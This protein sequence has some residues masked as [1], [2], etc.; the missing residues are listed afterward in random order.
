MNR[1]TLLDLSDDI[2]SI[3]MGLDS[4]DSWD[5]KKNALYDFL[6]ENLDLI[7]G[8]LV[9]SHNIGT[10][11]YFISQ[12]E[13]KSSAHFKFSIVAA[14]LNLSYNL[15]DN[16]TLFACLDAR[17][18]FLLLATNHDYFDKEL[19]GCFYSPAE[20]FQTDPDAI[21]K[22]MQ[23]YRIC[24]YFYLSQY[25]IGK[26]A[27]DSLSMLSQDEQMVFHNK[28]NKVIPILEND[29]AKKDAIIENG[30]KLLNVLKQSICRQI[31]IWKTFGVV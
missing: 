1:L 21:M 19:A 10:A 24:I 4:N 11:F 3:A 9:L 29:A 25:F 14:F 5:E 6:E 8:D 16:D 7:K 2:T 12:R 20:I 13:N 31:D 27:S 28:F 15:R 30:D 22:R 23:K 17:R 26:W 18:V